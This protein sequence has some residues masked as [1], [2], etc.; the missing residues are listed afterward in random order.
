M[1]IIDE[2]KTNNQQMFVEKVHTLQAHDEVMQ[3]NQ[4]LEE[5]LT[6]VC[7]E[8]PDLQIL[9]E[10]TFAKKIHK[11]DAA[12]KESKEEIRKMSFELQ[13]HISEL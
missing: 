7:N 1:L 4:Q 8:L 13:L 6:Q 3:L 9:A 12:V 10:A 5:T 11:L 2:V